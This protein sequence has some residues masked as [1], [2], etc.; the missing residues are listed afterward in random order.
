MG[1]DVLYIIFSLLPP[2]PPPPHHPMGGG[3]WA[4]YAEGLYRKDI[5]QIAILGESC[6]S[7]SR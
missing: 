4:I 1:C 3:G 5:D 6:H 2:P 7:R